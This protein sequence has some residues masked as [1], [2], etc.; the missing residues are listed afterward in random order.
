MR[1]TS[2]RRVDGTNVDGS[3]SL[4]A[5]QP[6]HRGGDNQS[7]REDHIDYDNV[8]TVE[9]GRRDNRKFLKLPKALFAAAL[10]VV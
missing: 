6:D 9:R 7:T 3:P 4:A 2:C 8:S 10:R 5:N 1:P